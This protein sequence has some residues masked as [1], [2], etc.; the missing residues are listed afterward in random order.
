M[1]ASDLFVKCLEN[2]GVKYVFGVPGEETE[3]ILFSLEKSSIK[4][5]P[6]RHEQGAAFMA[7]VWGRVSGQAGVCLSTLGPG[8]T[9]LVTGVAD[10][11]SDKSPVVAIS[12]QA[13]QRRLHKESHQYI[14]LVELFRPITKW[15]STI[16]GPDVIAEVVR[17]AF[18]IAES[19]K[20]GA[21]HIEFPEDI[22]A[23]KTT[24]QPIKVV[25]V[26]RPDPD[27]KALRDAVTLLKKA[28]YPLILAGN[29][30]V[31]KLASEELNELV[32]KHQIPVVHTFMGQGAIADTSPQSL[33]SIGFNFRDIV[34]DAVDQAD[35]IITVG[36]DI[37][38]YSPDAWNKGNPKK[39]I[40]I[41][42][43][44]AEVYSHYQPTVEIV[45]DVHATLRELNNLLGSEDCRFDS[46]W[47]KDI[48]VRIH[49]DILSY[50]LKPGK[51]FTIPGVLD[52]L[53]SLMH[54][55]DLLISD[56]GSHKLWIARNFS[57]TCPNGVII[58]NGL[59]SMGIALP[60]AVA[61]ALHSPQRR[62]VAAMGDGGFMMNSQELE[63]AK[64]LGLGFVVLIFNDND[65]GLISWK[66]QMS[67]GRSTGTALTN[68]D[69]K[70]YAESF[71]I[72]GYRPKGLAELRKQ[73][74]KSLQNKELC[75]FEIPI[76]TTVNREL[77][78]KLKAMQ[79]KRKG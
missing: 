3:D 43:T 4:F 1:K 26:R 74:T 49:R 13:D 25:R 41:D 48:R 15:N 14:N 36:Y 46:N 42:F 5:I 20:P 35:L 19:E 7:D 22:A 16:S 59:A 63:T 64:R 38:E 23:M 57:A 50:E 34:M 24:S 77:I 71:G 29:G 32:H 33:F 60:G 55:D 70:K 65:Y 75:V 69:F 79:K 40:H 28:K 67:Q 30:A 27:N 68:P 39:I 52:V 6:T 44:S 78:K 47:Y 11:N 37:A 72:K 12:A 21:T 10:A 54:G 73:L 8:A 18:K 76:V 31:R 58:S 2:E 53:Q 62:I 9:N 56:V 51:P 61:A 66:Q 17:K 45:A